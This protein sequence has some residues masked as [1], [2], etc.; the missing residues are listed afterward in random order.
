MLGLLPVFGYAGGVV[1]KIPSICVVL[2]QFSPVLLCSAPA[3]SKA[4]KH[5]L[6]T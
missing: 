6:F 5:T 4:K 1:I 2:L 3:S